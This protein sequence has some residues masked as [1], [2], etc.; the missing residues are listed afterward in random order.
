M[1]SNIVIYTLF[2]SVVSLVPRLHIEY[3]L[4]NDCHWLYYLLRAALTEYQKLGGLKHKNLFSH[5]SRGLNFK[6]KASAG[7]VPSEGCERDFSMPLSQHLIASGVPWLIDG[8]LPVLSHHFPCVHVSLCVRIFPFYWDTN[9]I[10]LV[11]I[12]MPSS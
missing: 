8:I 11:P 1:G 12:L 7:L 6:I 3:K 5:S 4:I 9:H 10:G 2:L